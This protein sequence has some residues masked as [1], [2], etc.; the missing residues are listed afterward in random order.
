[1]ADGG[2]GGFEAWSLVFVGGMPVFDF[3]GEFFGGGGV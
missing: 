1:M 2:G 3:H